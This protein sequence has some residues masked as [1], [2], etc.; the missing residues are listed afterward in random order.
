MRKKLRCTC[1][2]LLCALFLG[3]CIP[4]A[5]PA[6]P[7]ASPL[8]TA[9]PT[10]TPTPPPTPTPTP[11]PAAEQLSTMT[12][13]QKVSQLLVAG[14][15]GTDAGSDGV[16]AVETYQVGGLIYFSRNAQS[17]G[18]LVDLTNQLKAL[19]GDYI[20][21]FIGIDQ[22]GGR[23]DRMPPEVK[24]TPSAYLVGQAGCAS[25]YGAVLA[26]ECAAFGCNVDFAPSLDI[27]SNPDNTVIGNRAF[28]TD[29]D[30]V[31]SA[32]LEALSAMT[33]GGVIPVVKHFPGHGDT[34]EDSHVELPVVTDSLDTLRQEA[35]A[36]FSAAID[37]TPGGLPAVM[38]SHILL[39]AVD[40]TYPATLS[41]AV[42]DGLLREDLGFDG[43][44][45]TDDMTMGAIADTWSLGEACVLAINA[46]C[47][48]L[49]ICHGSDNLTAARNALLAAVGEGRIS[50][51]R[52]DESVSR[53]LRL[54]NQYHLTNDPIPETELSAL[55]RQIGALWD[56]I[57]Q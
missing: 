21:Q 2:L 39:T 41:P 1:V 17:A 15:A 33:A 3:G 27:W 44:V 10:A 24:D 53:I 32:G 35:L 48:C 45:F 18:Q 47:D 7:S 37:A 16:L 13:E 54:K 34:R 36:P 30:T 31:T 28:G 8:P 42:V 40:D 12:T 49:L 22:E 38:V 5:A 4:T 23:V 46:G 11:D 52:L 6:S 9:A 29:P 20:P 56:Q 19:N 43:V 57:N 26:A 51:E 25:D 55:N 50:Q 14:I